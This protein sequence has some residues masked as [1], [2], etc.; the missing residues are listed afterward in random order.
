[1]E[2]ETSTCM[3]YAGKLVLKLRANLLEMG[4]ETFVESHIRLGKK[5]SH[6]TNYNCK[7]LHQLPLS[8]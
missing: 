6:Y 7:I 1:M 5:L 4:D 2:T 8:F 3:K